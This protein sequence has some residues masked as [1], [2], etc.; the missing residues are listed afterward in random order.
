MEETTL[1]GL[2]SLGSLLALVIG[3]SGWACVKSGLAEEWTS[4]T[5]ICTAYLF[6]CFAD[7]KSSKEDEL[8]IVTSAFS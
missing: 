4:T 1:L 7:K 8:T 2:G 6:I 3:S 5:K